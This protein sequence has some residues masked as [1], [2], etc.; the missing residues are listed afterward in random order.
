MP[1]KSIVLSQPGPSSGPQAWTAIGPAEGVFVRPGSNVTI[2]VGLAGVPPHVQNLVPDPDLAFAVASE[3]SVVA[4]RTA[5][6]T[7]AL[8]VCLRILMSPAP[9]LADS[10]H[11]VSHHLRKCQLADML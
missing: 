10:R 8:L 5:A 7:T 4:S 3:T 1:S 9:W 6:T 2:P 11:N